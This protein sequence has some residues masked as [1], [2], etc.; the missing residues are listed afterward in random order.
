MTVGSGADLVND[1][2]L[3][4]QEDCAWHV[5]A[6][7]GFG[8]ESVVGIIFNADGLVGW[9][10]AVRL[11]TVLEAVQFPAGIADL[12]AS[13]ADVDGKALTHFRKR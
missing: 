8:E 13:L 1:R 6:G 12:A 7:A 10:G 5:L 2:G 3:Q 11:D 9:H 4:V